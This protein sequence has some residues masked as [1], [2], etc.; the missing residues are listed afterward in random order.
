MIEAMNPTSRLHLALFQESPVPRDLDANFARVAKAIVEVQADL[1]VFPE[2]FL[3][4]YQTE[5]LGEIAIGIEDPRVGELAR[6]CRENRRGL[7]VGFVESGASGTAGSSDSAAGPEF[8][9][10]YLAIDRDGQVLPTVR[11]THLFGGEREVFAAGAL[12]RPIDLC[13]T[14][15]GVVNCFEIEF[16]EVSRT[17]A[18]RGADLLIA[19]SAN[20]HPYELDHRAAA[21]ARALENRIPVAYANRV[22]SESGHDFCGLSRVVDRDGRILAELDAD[23]SAMIGATVDLIPREGGPTD[24]LAQRRP[25]L[26][27]H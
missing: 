16:P 6:A 17:L 10:S 12:L 20:M 21:V 19:G 13:G 3:S 1:L 23:E 14:R 26:Y 2:L 22:G 24:M 5:R 15:V 18:I 4:G 27:E 9:D 7:L 25:E 8:F 11:K